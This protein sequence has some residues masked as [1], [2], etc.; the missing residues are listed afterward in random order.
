MT[1]YETMNAIVVEEYGGI[2]Q[3]V[4]RKVIRPHKPGDAD[5]VVR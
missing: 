2:E 5:L 1:V 3:L 4:H